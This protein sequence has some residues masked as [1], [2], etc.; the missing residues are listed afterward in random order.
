MTDGD[1][2]VKLKAHGWETTARWDEMFATSMWT[3]PLW[4]NLKYSLFEAYMF[5][6]TLVLIE[7]E[8]SRIERDHP[9]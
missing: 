3:H 4:P 8:L 6:D 9:A 2:G 1:M 7:Q 5:K